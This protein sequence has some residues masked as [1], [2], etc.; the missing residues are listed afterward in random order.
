[1]KRFFITFE[2]IEGCGK[3][4]QMHLLKDFLEQRGYAVTATREPGGTSLGDTIRKILLDSRNVTIDTKTELLLYEASRA[5]HVHE[6]IRPALER[7]DIVLCDRYTDATLAYQSVAQGI[8]IEVVENLN[9]FATDYLTPDFTIL[10]DCPA[11][12]GLERALRRTHT[13]SHEVSEDRF[14]KKSIAFHQKVRW[15]Y[16]QLAERYVH[17]IYIADGREEPSRVHQEIKNVVLAKL[18]G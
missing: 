12:I 9:Q 15:G 5:Q 3:T 2:G 10:I 11:E 7:G 18:E 17:R 8:L 14:E 4:T 6:V 16:L 1:M 13:S